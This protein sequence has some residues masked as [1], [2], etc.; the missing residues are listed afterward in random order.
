MLGSGG[1]MCVRCVKKSIV[2]LS[3]VVRVLASPQ[4]LALFV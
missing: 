4:H 2:Q 3:I 1:A